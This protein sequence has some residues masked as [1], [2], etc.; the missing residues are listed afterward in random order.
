MTQLSS[1]N[2][3][4]HDFSLSRF[5]TNVHI[6]LTVDIFMYLGDVPV[7]LD[8]YVHFVCIYHVQKI[9]VDLPSLVLPPELMALPQ[10]YAQ[11]VQQRRRPG[12]NIFTVR[13]SQVSLQ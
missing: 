8:N 4:F 11:V 13:E 7:S 3:S 5:N 2:K 1:R 6:S 12:S 10:I 9:E